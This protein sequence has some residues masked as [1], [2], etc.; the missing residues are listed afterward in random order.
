M[1]EFVFSD[2]M[3]L[4]WFMGIWLLLLLGWYDGVNNVNWILFDCVIVIFLLIFI[5]GDVG[6][7]EDFGYVFRKWIY[8]G[9]WILWI[10]G[11]FGNI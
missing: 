10:F 3:M 9:F 7:W 8:V 6:K 2:G 11:D 4:E 5:C 1:I